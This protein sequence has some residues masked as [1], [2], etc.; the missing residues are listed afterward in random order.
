MTDH[1]RHTGQAELAEPI[2][3]SR[4]DA[5]KIAQDVFNSNIQQWKRI[6]VALLTGFGVFVLLGVTWSDLR[7]FLFEKVYPASVAYDRL[8]ESLR[9]DD[10]LRMSMA[11]DL[12][13]LLGQRV[14]SGYSKALSFS[15]NQKMQSGQ[16]II[17]FYAME[18]Q[19]VELTIEATGPKTA[20]MALQ[21]D[22]KNPNGE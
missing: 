4:A 3:L 6:I 16:N 2:P 10:V 11:T 20:Q 9:K 15:P 14:D 22:N 8:K 17:Q 5:E 12:F 18:G 21:I 1:V 19:V 7:Y 13:E